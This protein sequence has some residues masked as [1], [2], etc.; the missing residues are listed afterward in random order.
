MGR[1]RSTQFGDLGGEGIKIDVNAKRASQRLRKLAKRYPEK[2]ADALNNE[3]EETLEDAKALTP[4]QFG[5]LKDEG[6]IEQYADAH[7][8]EVIID[9]PT[10]YAIF[11]HEIPPPPG[12]SDGGRSARHE[13]GEWK[14]LEKAMNRRAS[15]FSKR[16]AD[17]IASQIGSLA[18][19][20]TDA[21]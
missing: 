9:F 12:V 2:A 5:T 13:K 17:D 19:L 11:V 14:F 1:V 8:L 20:F 18:S 3:G 7:N 15:K 10:D 21:K 16:L 4:E 6:E